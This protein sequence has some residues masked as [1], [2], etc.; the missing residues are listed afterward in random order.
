[1]KYVWLSGLITGIPSALVVTPVDHTRIK[2]QAIEHVHYKS[3][4]DAG[5]TIFHNHGIRGLYQGFNVTVVNEVLSLGVYFGSYEY[6]LRKFNTTHTYPPSTIVSFFAGGFAG[7]LC[8]FFT[9]PIDY[10]KTIIQSDD[11]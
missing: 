11:T 4:I 6:L 5:L 1:M 10:I 9:Y 3:A 7:S 2:M 8:W